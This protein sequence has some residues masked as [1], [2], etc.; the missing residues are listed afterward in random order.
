M[1]KKSQKKLSE[2]KQRLT[3][4]FKGEGEKF[5]QWANVLAV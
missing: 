3:K 4:G 5:L 2:G 1:S